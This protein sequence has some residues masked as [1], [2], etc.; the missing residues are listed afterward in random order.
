MSEDR[1]EPDSLGHKMNTAVLRMNNRL[2]EQ[3]YNER[4]RAF[5]WGMTVDELRGFL[6]IVWEH[7]NHAE[8][9]E[10]VEEKPKPKPPPKPEERKEP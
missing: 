3:G 5:M 6:T 4:E 7:V 2:K 9:E 8:K 1:V 10:L